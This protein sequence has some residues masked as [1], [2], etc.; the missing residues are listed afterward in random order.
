MF[1]RYYLKPR[2]FNLKN[3]VSK[4]NINK[5]NEKQ[6]SYK[7]NL[8]YNDFIKIYKWHNVQWPQKN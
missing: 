2:Y 8:N 4:S 7:Q 5:V 6:I 1:R 3:I